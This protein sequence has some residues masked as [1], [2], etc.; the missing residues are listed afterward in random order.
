M[1]DRLSVVIP[2]YQRDEVV[3]RTVDAVLAL[4]PGADVILVDQTPR[5]DDAAAA[6]LRCWQG[7]GRVCHVRQAQ[8]NIPAAMNAG[9]A[10]ARTPCVLFLDDDIQPGPGL[11]TA[12]LAAMAAYPDCWCTA[13]RVVQMQNEDR[14][15][16]A[17]GGSRKRP[18]PL[19]RDQ[20]FDFDGGLAGY[21]TDVMAGN[22]CVRR[23]RALA[24]GGFDERFVGAAY[25]F[26]SD[27]ARRVVRAGG[28]IRFV[29]DAGVEHLNWP[30]G[31]TRVYGDRLRTWR[32]SFT[33]GKYYY[34]MRTGGAELAYALLV[35]PWRDPATRHGLRH[36]WCLPAQLLAELLGLCYATWLYRRGTILLDP[37]THHPSPVACHP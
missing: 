1:R 29:P 19:L 13:G 27:F 4:A 23:D 36:P 10:R 22:L 7:T 25:R 18:R 20:A 8:P 37:V 2:S 6:A 14:A 35:R 34:A 16:R 15:L 26:E 30:T 5:H 31:G 3:V 11:L 21:I 32:P 9:L 33:V 17:A 28:R 12:H 24:L